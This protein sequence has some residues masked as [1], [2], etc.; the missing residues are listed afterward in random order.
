MLTPIG[1]TEPLAMQNCLKIEPF[2]I[3]LSIDII[4]TVRRLFTETMMSI[5]NKMP[6]RLKLILIVRSRE[7]NNEIKIHHL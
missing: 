6:S 5:D 4:I 7:A 1:T 2:G 3:L